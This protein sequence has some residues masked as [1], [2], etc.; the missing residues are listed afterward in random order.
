MVTCRE[1]P[2][3]QAPNEADGNP[4]PSIAIS[5][6]RGL[7]TQHRPFQERRLKACMKQVVGGAFSG[8]LEEEQE[9]RI[10]T[11][12]GEEA[13]A[14]RALEARFPTRSR[15][16]FEGKLDKAVDKLVIEVRR[17]LEPRINFYL[18]L[19]ATKL[20]DPTFTLSWDF[21]DNN[22]QKFCDGLLSYDIFG[23]VFE[24][25]DKPSDQTDSATAVPRP[26]YLMSFVCRP[27]SYSKHFARTKYDVPNGLTEEYLLKFRYGRH[28]HADIFD[29]LQE[30]WYDLGN[31]RG[32]LYKYQP[33]FPWDCTEAY[34]GEPTK[35]NSCA[36]S[37]HVWSF[38]FDSW[39]LIALHLQKDRRWYPPSDPSKLR[40]TDAE[41]MANR[42]TLLL[43][44]D[45]LLQGALALRAP[46]SGSCGWI[47]Q[48]AR[49]DR[50]RLGGIHRAQ[51]L[52]HHYE[53]GRFQE[54]YVTPWVHLGR[55]EQIKIYESIRDHRA[56][57]PDMAYREPKEG[58]RWGQGDGD[59]GFQDSRM[60]PTGLEDAG[61]GAPW[62]DPAD[63]QGGGPRD[64]WNQNTMHDDAGGGGS[65]WGDSG[66]GGNGNSGWGS[67][68][69]GGD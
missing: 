15:V 11:M 53:R 61:N 10:A 31:F 27:E 57:M 65:G 38:P 9:K 36:L 66:W 43:A 35:C 40:P 62:V 59:S 67:D 23:R 44:Q 37:K 13:K 3:L 50:L 7:F 46:L 25:L 33:L 34:G 52:S 8:F 41:W 12:L 28:D 48:S 4:L 42:L 51:P 24:P 54:A 22:C 20:M 39:S 47:S 56:A 32:P 5:E 16:W 21:F 68:G 58:S 18:D 60:V 29:T 2:H 17:L 64:A 1:P 63:M 6:Q 30:Y 69:G 19:V 45:V 49:F 26:L 14:Y 55:A